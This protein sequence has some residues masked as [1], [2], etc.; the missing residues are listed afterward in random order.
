MLGLSCVLWEKAQAAPFLQAPW[1]KYL[2]FISA[3]GK[4]QPG[5]SS[6]QGSMVQGQQ[7]GEG[8]S[9]NIQGTEQRVA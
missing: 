8:G 7:P 5:S 9:G 1:T 2:H 4:S 6:Q 3:Q